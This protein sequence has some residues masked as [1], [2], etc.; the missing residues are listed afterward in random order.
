MRERV[1]MCTMECVWV[2]ENNL[3]DSVLSLPHVG[4]GMEFKLS[5]LVGSR[6][7]LPTGH[8][9]G[10]NCALFFIFNFYLCSCVYMCHVCAGTWEVQKRVPDLLKLDLQVAVNHSV[11]VLW[12]EVNALNQGAT[13]PSL[14]PGILFFK[15]VGWRAAERWLI[16]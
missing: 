8:R 9:G 13:Q 2:L 15:G 5:G 10:C 6:L 16:K 11:S 7:P 12:T 3:Q 4:P 1:Y 14:Q